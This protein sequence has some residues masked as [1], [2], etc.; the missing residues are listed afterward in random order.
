MFIKIFQSF[1]QNFDWSLNDRYSENIAQLGWA[2]SIF[3][4]NKFGGQERSAD[5][6]AEQYSKAFP[7]LTKYFMTSSIYPYSTPEIMFKRCYGIR[8]FERFLLWFGLVRIHRIG[9]ARD[10]NED[11]IIGSDLIKD[12]F[13]LKSFGEAERAGQTY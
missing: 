5:F 8:T 9:Q 13:D 7:M 12:L 3:L 1:T 11:K 10:S 2:Y 4:I 6:Y